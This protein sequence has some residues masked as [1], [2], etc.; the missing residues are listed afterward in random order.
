M[1]LVNATTIAIQDMDSLFKRNAENVLNFVRTAIPPMS[2]LA[3]AAIVLLGTE[4][5]HLIPAQSVQR[6]VT[7]VISRMS[8]LGNAPLVQMG[9]DSPPK[10]LA[11]NALMAARIVTLLMFLLDNAA[12]AIMAMISRPKRRAPKTV[13]V[14]I[15]A[16]ITAP[17]PNL[18]HAA[19]TME[20]LEL[21]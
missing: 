18:E 5:Q 4:F 11:P 8:L 19:K 6:A 12:N 9:L 7:T 3:N 17:S 15:V 20:T 1:L 16:I 2:P 13:H 14:T 10:T 21:W